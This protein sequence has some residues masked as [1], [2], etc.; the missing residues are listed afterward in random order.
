MELEHHSPKSHYLRTNRKNF[1][2]QQGDIEQGQARIR[3]ICQKL[4][5]NGKIQDILPH[6]KP[7]KSPASNYHIGKTQ[8]YPVDLVAIAQKAYNDPAAQVF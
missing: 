7:P 1:E 5:E 8:N 6:E 2:K 3:Q 4:N